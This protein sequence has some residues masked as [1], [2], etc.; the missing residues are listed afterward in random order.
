[1][2]AGRLVVKLS[3]AIATGCTAAALLYSILRIVQ[4]VVLPEPDPATVM[5]T[6]HSGFF[7]RAWI[8]AYVAGAVA[9]VAHRFA[10]ERVARL[11]ARAIVPVAAI[12]VLQAVL[13]P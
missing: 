1:M 10:G 13:V 8:S 7:W 11:L 5:W 9:L 12:V 3:L 6:E 2:P 4:A